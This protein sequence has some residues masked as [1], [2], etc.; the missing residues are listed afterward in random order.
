HDL[1]V[2]AASIAAVALAV[3]A[4]YVVWAIVAARNA[5][6]RSILA[7]TPWAVIGAFL[8]GPVIVGISASLSGPFGAAV[9]TIGVTAS[10]AG[11]IVGQL[12]LG[13]TVAAL[14]GRGRIF[15]HWLGV[16]ILTG[17]LV[18]ITS[19]IE[20]RPLETVILA[21]VQTAVVLLNATL[22]WNAMSTL[23]RTCRAYRYGGSTVAAT[24]LP[25]PLASGANPITGPIS[26]VALEPITVGSSAL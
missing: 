25:T 14:D 5:H 12:V 16:D 18:S 7:P 15:T 17:V 20:L 24:T 10:I 22:A 6:R 23:D 26:A 9:L 4:M 3:H 21:V 8:S 19:L 11:F 1:R 2:A 13:R